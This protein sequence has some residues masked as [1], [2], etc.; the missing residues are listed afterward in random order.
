MLVRPKLVRFRYVAMPLLIA[1]AAVPLLILCSAGC[2]VALRVNHRPVGTTA[3]PVSVP[4]VPF[5]PEEGA[6]STGSGVVRTDLYADFGGNAS[7]IENGAL[8][9]HPRGVVSTI[10]EQL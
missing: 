10:A 3:T 7:W 5:L 2:G 8:Q 6:V 9:S 1:T 4:G